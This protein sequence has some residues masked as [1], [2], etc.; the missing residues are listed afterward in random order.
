MN[1][2]VL[3]M[4]E[5]ALSRAGAAANTPEQEQGNLHQHEDLHSGSHGGLI[6]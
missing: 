5:R 6:L 3:Q 1:R 4:A 2:V